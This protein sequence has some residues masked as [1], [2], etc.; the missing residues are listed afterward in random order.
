[1]RYDVSMQP[2]IPKTPPPSAAH[3]TLRY[4]FAILGSVLLC[5][6]GVSFAAAKAVPG[7]ILHP[8][9]V[10]V[11]EPAMMWLT[12]IHGQDASVAMSIIA[13]RIEELEILNSRDMLTEESLEIINEHLRLNLMQTG[14]YPSKIAKLNLSESERVSISTELYA[15]LAVTNAWA[16]I[17]ELDKL[18]DQGVSF[19]K[20][21]DG[22]SPERANALFKL[23]EKHN[24]N[25]RHKERVAEYLGYY[26][27]ADKIRQEAARAANDAE[28]R[29]AQA[30]QAQVAEYEAQLEETMNAY[31]N[32]PG[33]DAF[34]RAN[35]IEKP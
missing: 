21:R 8:F 25:G 16:N 12:K 5:A 23:Y 15:Y 28:I 7:D 26:I 30:A 11:Q 4:M 33:F 32:T 19:E 31:L 9:K 6:T 3:R 34:N 27:E 35:G 29:A 10:S 1:M 13:R 22:Y 24:P 18:L 17:I 14:L 2:F 20:I